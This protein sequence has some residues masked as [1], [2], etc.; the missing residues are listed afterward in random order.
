MEFQKWTG[1]WTWIAGF[2]NS[3]Y[4]RLSVTRDFLLYLFNPCL[5]LC[6]IENSETVELHI[7]CCL[8]LAFYSPRCVLQ[9][10]LLCHKT[11]RKSDGNFCLW[12]MVFPCCILPIYLSP[13]IVK[14]TKHWKVE[15]LSTPDTW[16]ADFTLPTQLPLRDFEKITRGWEDHGAEHSG[17]CQKI[18][19]L[20][21]W[22]TVRG[23]PGQNIS[24]TLSQKQARHGATR[25]WSQ[26][27]RSQR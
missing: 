14:A 18:Q 23:Q 24:K 3:S 26:L 7:D 17:S 13:A 9:H 20:R 16:M 27:L 4:T 15:T 6:V 2:E 10:T 5:W 25:M 1:S 21:R 12:N 22:I 19:L 11:Q 8:S